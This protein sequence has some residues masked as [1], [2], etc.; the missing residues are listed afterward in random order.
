V[1]DEL[2][3]DVVPDELPVMQELVERLMQQAY[4]GRVP[5]T[6]EAGVGSD[7]LAAH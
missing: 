6:A 3:F 1:H 2:N 5:L 4:T 7:W